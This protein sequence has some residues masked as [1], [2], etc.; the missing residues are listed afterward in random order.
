[1]ALDIVGSKRSPASLAPVAAYSSEIQHAMR[2]TAILGRYQR[3]YWAAP[4][5][6]DQ[7]RAG[8]VSADPCSSRVQQRGRHS[9]IPIAAVDLATRAN[10]L[11]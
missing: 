7:D 1:V 4:L 8:A 11:R 5:N 2:T 9:P 6:R 10:D 3:L